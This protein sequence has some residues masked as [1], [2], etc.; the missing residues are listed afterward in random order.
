VHETTQVPVVESHT[1]PASPQVALDTHATQAW[2]VVLQ[3]GRAPVPQ[4]VSERQATQV[5]PMQYGVGAAHIASVMHAVP[6]AAS[7]PPLDASDDPPEDPL[8]SPTLPLE[9]AVPLEAPLLPL[10]PDDAVPLEPPL[11]SPAPEE[12]VPELVPEDPLDAPEEPPSPEPELLLLPPLHPT[13]IPTP[14]AIE[15]ATQVLRTFM[16]SSRTV[17]PGCRAHSF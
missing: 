5:P 13:P 2:V 9:E 10:P 11:S 4:F 16:S 7:D 17:A 15:R 14:I 1:R 6:I 3:K 12:V 8:A